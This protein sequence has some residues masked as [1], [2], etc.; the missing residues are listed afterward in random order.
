M[1][2]HVFSFHDGEVVNS[3]L[4]VV[5]PYNLLDGYYCLRLVSPVSS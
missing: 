5:A 3:G 2:C 4:L 1:K